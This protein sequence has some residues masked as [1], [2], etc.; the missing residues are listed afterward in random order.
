MKLYNKVQLISDTARLLLS[1]LSTV[2][3]DPTYAEQ[4][5]ELK[6]RKLIEKK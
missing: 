3:D 1:K 5:K 2:N 4:L 6:K